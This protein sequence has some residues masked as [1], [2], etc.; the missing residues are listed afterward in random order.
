M[1][2]N[3]EQLKTSI[4]THHALARIESR[5]L[6]MSMSKSTP[7]LPNSLTRLTCPTTAKPYTDHVP[8]LVRPQQVRDPVRWLQY[9]ADHVLSFTHREYVIPLDG[10]SLVC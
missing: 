7:D 9:H 5:L 4:S 10:C 3:R 6:A 2:A 8:S 1:S